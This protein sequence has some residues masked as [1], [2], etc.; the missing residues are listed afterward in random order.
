MDGAEAI[1][2]DLPTASTHVVDVPLEAGDEQGTGVGRFGSLRIVR[3]RSLEVLEA[4]SGRVVVIGGDCGVQ[5]APIGHAL[6][7]AN[8]DVAVVW[9]D[10]QPDLNTAA[11]SPSGAFSGMVL[12]ALTGDGPEAI[13]P[14]V[15]LDPSRIILAGA[16]SIDEGEADYIE[17]AGIRSLSVDQLQQADEL[18]AAIEATGAASVYLHIDLDVLDPGELEGIG[19]PVPFGLAASTL[20]ELIRAVTSRFAIAGAGVASYSPASPEDSTNDL[21]TILRLIGALAS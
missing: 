3:D 4:L 15:L 6:H 11:S 5:L 20:I 8:G 14:P 10:A 13:V 7:Q 9:F 16:R 21:P 17:T 2:G 12:R 1:R 19:E 18:V